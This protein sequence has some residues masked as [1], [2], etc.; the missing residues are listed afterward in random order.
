MS[1]GNYEIPTP[2]NEKVYSFA[3]GTPERESLKKKVDELAGQQIDIPLV[4]DGKE[5]RTG[6]TGN[7][8]M[9]H[10][11]GHVLATGHKGPAKEI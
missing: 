11:H 9:P 6:D 3:Q 2:V 8:V 1:R 4:I 7:Y 5:V 10:D